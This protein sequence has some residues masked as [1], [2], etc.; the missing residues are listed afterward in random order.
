MSIVE[1]LRNVVDPGSVLETDRRYLVDETETRSLEGR[2]D[3]VVLPRTVDE[4]AAVMAW[5]YE[6]EVP[7]TPRGGGTGYA[8]GCVR[9]AAGSCSVS[10]GSTACC[11]STRCS[12]AS[13]CRPV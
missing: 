8:G 11:A 2:A 13:T 9:P 12:G 4:V 7:L 5:C 6:R 10:T 3:A 1:A